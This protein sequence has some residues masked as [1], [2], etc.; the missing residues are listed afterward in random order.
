MLRNVWRR[1]LAALYLA[2]LA[3]CGF[4]PMRIPDPGGMK[5]G[6][7]LVTGKTGE[8]VIYGKP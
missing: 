7:G 5:P 8:F 4:E 2:T 6:P 1:A 3:G